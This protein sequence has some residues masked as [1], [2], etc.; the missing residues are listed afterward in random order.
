MNRVGLIIAGA[1]LSLLVVPGSQAQVKRFHDDSYARQ[2]PAGCI[3]GITRAL[4]GYDHPR[5]AA[6]IYQNNV[7]AILDRIY[8]FPHSSW[9]AQA[10]AAQQCNVDE[11]IARII[12]QAEFEQMKSEVFH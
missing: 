3:R 9:S 6:E 12:V 1:A 11:A 2:N 7:G 8:H 4:I 10:I 5:T